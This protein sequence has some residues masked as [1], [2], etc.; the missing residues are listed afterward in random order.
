MQT[1]RLKLL[2]LYFGKCVQKGY[3]SSK[4]A[5]KELLANAYV[6]RK[7]LGIQVA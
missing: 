1:L 3:K 4:Q 6:K 2:V 7:P 5:E